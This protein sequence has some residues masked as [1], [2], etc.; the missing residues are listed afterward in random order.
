MGEIAVWLTFAVKF[1]VARN[2]AKLCVFWLPD[3]FDEGPQFF[4]PVIK[5]SVMVQNFA[6]IGDTAENK[7]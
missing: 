6:A 3:F 4:G 1:E 5:L 7:K 2:R